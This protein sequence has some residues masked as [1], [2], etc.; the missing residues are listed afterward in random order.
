MEGGS[1]PQTSCAKSR[2]IFALVGRQINFDLKPSPLKLDPLG[3]DESKFIMIGGS[4]LSHKKAF[5][6]KLPQLSILPM[7]I[8]V[9]NARLETF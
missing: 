2:Q 9:R 8:L 4:D 6:A 3:E 7:A 5:N 1:S